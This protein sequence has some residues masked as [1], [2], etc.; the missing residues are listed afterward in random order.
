MTMS[1][2]KTR[3]IENGNEENHADEWL[4]EIELE[5][6]AAGLSLYYVKCDLQ[7]CLIV[8]FDK[9]AS[10][11]QRHRK[12]RSQTHFEMIDYYGNHT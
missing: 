2:R 10:T 7:L 5:R 11:S 6:A 8:M 9:M 4:I 1:A 3:F 12:R